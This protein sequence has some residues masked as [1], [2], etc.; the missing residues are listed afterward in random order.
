MFVTSLSSLGSTIPRGTRQ[1]SSSA[2]APICEVR[3]LVCQPCLLYL[4]LDVVNG[5]SEFFEA[6]G[7]DSDN[8]AVWFCMFNNNQHQIA[9]QIKEFSFWVDSFQTALRAIGNVVMVLSPWNNPTTLTRTWCVFQIYVAIV[10]NAR[11][12]VTMGK[13]QKQS[14][15]QD[16]HDKIPFFDMLGTIKCEASQTAVPS[17]YDNIRNILK[18]PNLK[19]ADLDRMVFRVFQELMVR[20]VQTQIE[21]SVGADKARWHFVMGQLF[22]AMESLMD[23]QT[24]FEAAVAIYENQAPIRWKAVMNL[25]CIAET[26]GQPKS[27]WQSLLRQALDNQINYLGCAHVDTLETMFMLG[28]RYNRHDEFALGM[29]L[30]VAC[31]ETG[32]RLLGDKNPRLLYVVEAIGSGHLHQNEV[33]EAEQW[34]QS[35]YAHAKDMLGLDNP[36]TIIFEETLA[37]VHVRRGQYD[38]AQRIYRNVCN[39]RCRIY[40]SDEMG[41]R[42]IYSRLGEIHQRLG[43]YETAE[44]IL[45]EC[46]DVATKRSELFPQLQF[47][48]A[49][50][51]GMLYLAMGDLRRAETHLSQAHQGLV[52]Y[53]GPKFSE[54]LLALYRLCLLNMESSCLD[55]MDEIESQLN[56]AEWFEE[57]WSQFFCNGCYQPICG[58]IYSC[59]KCPKFVYLFCRPCVSQVKYAALCTH[60]PT[61]AFTPPA[62]YFQEKRLELLAQEQ[63]WR[64]YKAQYK[65]YKAYCATFQVPLDEQLEEAV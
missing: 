1:S 49:V 31:F 55:R 14:F 23:A 29:P 58:S 39:Q 63:K 27:V 7:L 48:V 22:L 51:L 42:R 56:Q 59:E 21:T 4:F 28:A 30:L 65:A 34:L 36:R 19:F 37:L 10:T 32:C 64:L 54:I 62:R 25:G 24:S 40:G 45:L 5:L 43:A 47:I 35:G 53:D 11:F 20:T 50:R 9:N 38:C 13:T 16:I 52:Q 3:D 33:D 41:T 46:L 60:V 15:L 12:E 57:T 61:V 6:E 18:P 8:V 17:D 44:E 2:K 26:Q